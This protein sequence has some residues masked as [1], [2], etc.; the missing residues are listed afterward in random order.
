M[1]PTAGRTSR[2][3]ALALAVAALTAGCGGGSDPVTKGAVRA[4]SS[5]ADEALRGGSAFAD[6]ASRAYPSLTAPARRA[7]VETGT[8]GGG[9][10]LRHV[11]DATFDAFCQ[12][13][14]W[15]KEYGGF[16]TADQ[17]YGIAEQRIGSLA[18]R[19]PVIV[20]RA[21]S[22][23]AAVEYGFETGNITAAQIDL[24]CALR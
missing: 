20:T 18:Y 9:T 6:D 15:Y 8:A 10:E 1:T 24:A 17:W 21:V 14:T 11:G 13:W 22:A 16:P 2:W 23:Y 5:A 19:Y 7:A 12:G 3:L 4:I